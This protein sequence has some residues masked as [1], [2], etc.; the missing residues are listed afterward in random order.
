VQLPFRKRAS[1]RQYLEGVFEFLLFETRLLVL[2][3]SEA[4]RHA[5]CHIGL[6]IFDRDYWFEGSREQTIRIM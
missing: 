3:G 6:T 5:F 4:T 2:G 1:N